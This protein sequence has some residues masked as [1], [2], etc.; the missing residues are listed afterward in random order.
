[1]AIELN[2]NIHAKVNRPTD[3]RFGPFTSIAQA[4]STIPIAQRYHGLIFGVYTNPGNIATSNITFYY[5]WDGLTDVDYLPLLTNL[6]LIETSSPII[7]FDNMSG[8]VHGNNSPITSSISFDFSQAIRGVVN[9]MTHNASSL[10]F[11]IQGKVIAGYY[12]PNV[13]NY[14]SFQLINKSLSNEVVWI[15]I[16]QDV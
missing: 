3:F 7:K 15:T 2:D 6:E 1:M 14:I 10:T 8:Y 5:Y 11:P 13:N 16:S 12:S 4:N 9:F